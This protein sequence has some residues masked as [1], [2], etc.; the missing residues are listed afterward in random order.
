VHRLKPLV[1]EIHELPLLNFWRC[2]MFIKDKF[3]RNNQ[4]T[5]NIEKTCEDCVNKIRSLKLRV[6]LQIQG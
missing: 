5:A 3:N 1:G 4:N 6:L 2:L